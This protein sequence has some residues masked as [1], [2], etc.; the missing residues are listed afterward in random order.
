MY[1]IKIGETNNREVVAFSTNKRFI[2]ATVNYMDNIVAR[3][4]K[5]ELIDIQSVRRKLANVGMED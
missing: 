1:M 5:V 4:P 2:T 3:H